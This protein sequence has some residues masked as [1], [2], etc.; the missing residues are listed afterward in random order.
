MTPAT[1]TR[2]PRLRASCDG[3]FLA[4]VK[5]SKARP[6]CARCL[7]CGILCNYSPSSRA[8]K[9][10]PESQPT[11]SI[12]APP[13]ELQPPMNTSPDNTNN[14]IPYL[15][16]QTQNQAYALNGPWTMPQAGSNGPMARNPSLESNMPLME[17]DNAGLARLDPISAAH[18]EFYQSHTSPWV[19]TTNAPSSIFPDVSAAG[20]QLPFT[21]EDQSFDGTVP[22]LANA[23]TQGMVL[24]PQA[25]TSPDAN[26]NYL[27]SP[28]STPLVE[29]TLY[30]T[31]AP[32]ICECFAGCLQSLLDL[33]NASAQNPIPLNL[34]LAVNEK[35]V[36]G[37]AVLM[38]CKR[39]LTQ[40]GPDTT[41]MV[42]T[43]IL[44]KSASSY[45]AALY[46]HC[47]L[48]PRGMLEGAQN[49][50]M[51]G[52]QYPMH[53]TYDKLKGAQL[54]ATAVQKLQDVFS[55][56]TEH[57]NSMNM[58]P[59]MEGIDHLIRETLVFV[60]FILTHPSNNTNTNVINSAWGGLK[61]EIQT[62]SGDKEVAWT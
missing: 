8:G 12:Q 62:T 22:T 58:V 10:K 28:N 15:P 34:V 39:C 52:G 26:L 56:F 29:P 18:P 33:H 41:T 45:R 38:T 46:T 35:A 53:D 19:P 40:S 32:I 1:K 27:P 44:S 21:A 37:C 51:S 6:C 48:G 30:P 4:K 17:L 43:A 7:T 2:A 3:C 36:D 60:E 5:C 55:G 49:G 16:T 11:S 20:N 42:L 31:T 14:M 50:A 25:H 24:Y 23:T 59:S 54:L 61:N 57:C 13:R 9:P 47:G